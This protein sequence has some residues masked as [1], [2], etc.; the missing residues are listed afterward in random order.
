MSPIYVRLITI[1]I[2]GMVFNDFE[3]QTFIRLHSRLVIRLNIKNY[4][5]S[6]LFHHAVKAV[7]KQWTA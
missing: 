5:L 6:P 3:A 7:V 4:P 1:R 2:D